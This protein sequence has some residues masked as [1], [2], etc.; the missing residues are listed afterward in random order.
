MLLI[1][2]L[3]GSGLPIRHVYTFPPHTTHNTHYVLLLT[4]SIYNLRATVLWTWVAEVAL[5]LGP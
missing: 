2:C 3:G 5:V 1:G 4:V